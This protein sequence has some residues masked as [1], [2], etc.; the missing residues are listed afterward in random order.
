MVQPPSAFPRSPLNAPHGIKSEGQEQNGSLPACQAQ[1]RCSSSLA[2][3]SLCSSCQALSPQ[4][5]YQPASLW[6]QSSEGGTAEPH[7]HHLLRW[8][9]GCVF[10]LPHPPEHP[11]PPTPSAS[12]HFIQIL[13][14]SRGSPPTPLSITNL[15]A[16]PQ[17]KIILMI[18][19]RNEESHWI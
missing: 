2:T 19:L 18:I 12:P 17:K 4:T 9:E 3:S 7:G 1:T 16:P 11:P 6:P 13:H 15:F 5:S 14:L 8:G 10:S